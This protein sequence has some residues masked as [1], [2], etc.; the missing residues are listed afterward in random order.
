M[1]GLSLHSVLY[2]F[3][4]F[5]FVIRSTEAELI[6]SNTG[7]RLDRDLTSTTGVVRKYDFTISRSFISPD[8]FN[9]SA[10]LVNGL[11]PGP[12]IEANYGDTFEITV[13]NNITNP[14]EGTTIHWHGM[15][16]TGTPY[17]DGVAA[18][19]QCPIAPGKSMVY[20]FLAD[21]YGSSFYH[22]HYSSQYIDGIFGP[23]IIN[24]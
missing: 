21:S 3:C 16:Q 4:V 6:P 1:V 17:Y 10:L 13:N 8:G 23:I 15:L 5:L 9:K 2:L 20:T 18:I 19:S 11:F 24:G 7:R 14:E 22:A 12:P